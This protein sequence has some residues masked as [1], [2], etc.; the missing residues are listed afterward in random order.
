MYQAY[1]G[2]KQS[3]FVAAQGIGA[4]ASAVLS[5]SPGHSEALARLA[6]LVESHGRLGLLLG[7]GG[8]GKSLVLAEFARE[9]RKVGACTALIGA[10]GYQPREFLFD[11]VSQWGCN[12]APDEET[13]Q[14]WQ[15][16]ARRLAELA[17]EQVPARILIDDCDAA[18]AEVHGL[19]TRLLSVPEAN[20]T[21]VAAAHPESLG[22]LG[23]RL[24]DQAALRID[25]SIWTE[26]ETRQ[27]LSSSLLEA[28]RLQPAFADQAVRRLFELS[29]GVPRKVNQLAELAL[30]AGA[31]ENLEQ[32][33][34]ET[35]NA[36]F[37]EL[38]LAR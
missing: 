32:I 28:G 37:D 14:L 26:Q 38:S 9:Q 11:L 10:T 27:Y 25:L 29:G 20:L 17:L 12:P 36:V 19:L 1:W 7:S 13:F 15:S 6:F 5:R 8:S 21:I 18:S 33:D 34:D 35:I 4:Q 23:S 31:G 24:V 22:R 30:V 16:A 3:P 2:L